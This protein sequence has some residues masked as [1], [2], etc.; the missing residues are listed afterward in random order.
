MGNVVKDLALNLIAG[1]SIVGAV[2]VAGDC[3]IKI[4]KEHE[5]E[6][7]KRVVYYTLSEQFKADR[8]RQETLNAY[9]QLEAKRT[10]VQ[11]A[12]KQ[13]V[14]AEYKRCKKSKACM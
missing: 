6:E 10:T 5:A 9:I 13:I 4:S 11:S 2:Y 3:W 14:Q 1:A 7:T 8:V 12:I